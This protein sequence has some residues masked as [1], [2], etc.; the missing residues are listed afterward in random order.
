MFAYLN[1]SV[2]EEMQFKKQERPMQYIYDNKATHSYIVFEV[3]GVMSSMH[4]NI[5]L[6]VFFHKMTKEDYLLPES[7]LT[8]LTKSDLDLFTQALHSSVA[9]EQLEAFIYVRREQERYIDSDGYE[10]EIAV[11]SKEEVIL[12]YGDMHEAITFIV[13]NEDFICNQEPLQESMKYE[14]LN[15]RR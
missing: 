15:T 2:E 12:E 8:K 5:A 6:D 4:P 3:E 11:R 9:L 14:I 10:Y 7:L 13:D 1:D